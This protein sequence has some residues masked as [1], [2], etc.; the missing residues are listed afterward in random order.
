MFTAD[1]LTSAKSRKDLLRI[2]ADNSFD[3]KKATNFI[4]YLDDL[5]HLQ[6]SW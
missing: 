1:E 3:P 5:R 4:Q 2:A 6:A